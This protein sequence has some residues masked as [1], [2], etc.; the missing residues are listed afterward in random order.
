MN[1]RLN[2]G[3]ASALYVY[4]FCRLPLL[5]LVPWQEW[6]VFFKPL[7]SL[8]NQELEENF[9]SE[10]HQLIAIWLVPHTTVYK[11]LKTCFLTHPWMDKF[12]FSHFYELEM[13]NSASL[14][15]PGERDNF[16]LKSEFWQLHLTHNQLCK[17]WQL[18]KVVQTQV[19]SCIK[20]RSRISTPKCY[21]DN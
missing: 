13:L 8:T 14:V 9:L 17:H 7:F 11:K 15:E 2:W 16:V 5:I 4:F 3:N 12:C 1:T 21:N 18:F 20:M 19:S 10:F 6:F